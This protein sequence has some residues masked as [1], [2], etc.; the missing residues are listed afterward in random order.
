VTA[1]LPGRTRPSLTAPSPPFL[2]A[3]AGSPSFRLPGGCRTVRLPHQTA[4]VSKTTSFDHVSQ[5]RRCGS[6]L[7]SRPRCGGVVSGSRG[8]V[9]LRPGRVRSDRLG[10]ADTRG[11]AGA[12]TGDADPACTDRLLAVPL[13]RRV[14]RHRPCG[15]RRRRPV[16]RATVRVRAVGVRR[17]RT[18]RRFT[19]RQGPSRRRTD[20]RVDRA[21]RRVV[22]R[23]SGSTAVGAGNAR[24]RRPRRRRGVRRRQR[25]R[26]P[27]VGGQSAVRRSDG[28]RIERPR[29]GRYTARRRR[30]DGRGGPDVARA[31]DR[32]GRRRGR[33]D[34]IGRA[35]GGGAEHDS[36]ASARDV[37]GRCHG[38]ASRDDRRR[39]R[40]DHR[41]RKRD[42]SHGLRRRCRH[43]WRLHRGCRGVAPCG[44]PRRR[45]RPRRLG[46]EHGGGI[47]LRG[48]CGCRRRRR[49][50][51]S[52]R[53]RRR[54][55][56]F[57]DHPP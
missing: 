4:Y 47:R 46:P 16:R 34:A 29:P 43:H 26:R 14:P 27:R 28:G 57:R 20:G 12:R 35:R 24:V 11:T 39:E 13:R 37:R 6:R 54:D 21:V 23:R 32:D 19:R 31:T 9:G 38:R 48:R 25:R 3:R 42:G 17:G 51:V 52:D 15:C 18:R 56:R 22:R 44:G 40:D 55:A 8:G 10:G 53:H 49:P 33:P 2:A 30:S 1:C 41:R 5:S 7:P 50:R 45:R 36:A